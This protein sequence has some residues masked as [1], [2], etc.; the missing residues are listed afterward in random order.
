M[1]RFFI[2]IF[3]LAS[4]ALCLVSCGG[5]SEENQITYTSVDGTMVNPANAEAFGASIASNKYKDGVGTI[6]FKGSVSKIGEGAFADCSNLVSITIPESVEAVEGNPFEGCGN[7]SAFNG[8]FASK[9]H[10]SLVAGG[11]LKSFAPA[12][13]QTLEIAGDVTQ[14]GER[15]FAGC[16]S[17]L[18]MV[19]PASVKAVS[20][21]A[22]EGCSNLSS[23]TILGAVTTIA[24]KTFYGCKQLKTVV[25]PNSVTAIGE[26]AFGDC[27]ALKGVVIPAKVSF[28]GEGAFSACK[29]IYCNS[30]APA[31]T[32]APFGDAC[33]AIYVMNGGVDAYK[34]SEGWSKYEA[35]IKGIKD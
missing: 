23:V 22:F 1:K 32:E 13:L 10:R 12:K 4:L 19:V 33:E 21:A 18:S 29:T 7:L 24:P 20:E 26:G 15:A 6:R 16:T 31:K 11:V 27:D 8:K 35:L 5:G 34:S 2:P 25:I 3:V 9:D 14:I 28:I 17:L 30:E